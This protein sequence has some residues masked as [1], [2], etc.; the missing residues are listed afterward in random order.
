MAKTA[1]KPNCILT[2]QTK[3]LTKTLNLLNAAISSDKQS[4]DRL[5][6][7]VGNGQS[8]FSVKGNIGVEVRH[9][10]A[11]SHKSTPIQISCKQIKD[12]ASNLDSSNQKLSLGEEQVTVSN[13]K[14]TYQHRLATC[15]DLLP[16]DTS[17]YEPLVKV[18]AEEFKQALNKITPF[19]NS[20]AQE[21]TSGVCLK[22]EPMISENK[23]HDTLRLSLIG[24]SSAAM[25]EVTMTVESVMTGKL[26][27]DITLVLPKKAASFIANNAGDFTLS[28]ADT[29]VK[30]D[31]ENV[32][33]TVQT[34]KGEYPDLNKIKGLI[35]NNN[36]EVQFNKKELVSALKR[37]LVMSCRIKFK[38]E[39]GTCQ[40]TQSTETGSGQENI[41]C[42]TDSTEIIELDL[43]LDYLIKAISC[44]Q[45]EIILLKLNLK[46][47]EGKEKPD[48]P[49][50]I[51]QDNEIYCI[52]Q[53][54]SG[55]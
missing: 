46:P 27:K 3:E 49:I 22:V 40:L 47:D 41:C 36:I 17:E 34:L 15:K 50:R 43:R 13:Q 45:S 14:R 33:S 28:I 4:L 51:D 23:N 30:F 6:I 20:N 55:E 24:L 44:I 18:K 5:E 11:K 48:N 2:I 38:I 31:W 8:I 7:E 29:S 26:D 53:F 25:S 32:Q 35:E 16:Q 37:H 42:T 54:Q 52:S 39:E 21:I 12:L 10:A 1:S 19:L 9:K